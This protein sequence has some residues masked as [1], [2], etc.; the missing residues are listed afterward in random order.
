MQAEGVPCGTELR[1]DAG[2]VC[3]EVALP[4]VLPVVPLADHSSAC[5]CMKS[6]PRGYI[7]VTRPHFYCFQEKTVTDSGEPFQGYGND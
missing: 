4:D 2:P 3:A 1:L 6:R 5:R 7:Q